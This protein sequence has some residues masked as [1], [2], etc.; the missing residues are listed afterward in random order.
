MR[1]RI[2]SVSDVRSG[3]CMLY[4]LFVDNNE[5][6]FGKQSNNKVSARLNFYCNHSTLLTI[7]FIYPPFISTL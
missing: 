7:A 1:A 5:R 2:E 4:R 6:L 3:V